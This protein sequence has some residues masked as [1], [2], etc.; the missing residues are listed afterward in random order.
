M[1]SRPFVQY[2]AFEKETVS[3]EFRHQNFSRIGFHLFLFTLYFSETPGE[4]F[5][6]FG[7]SPLSMTQ[8]KY[9]SVSLKSTRNASSV[10]MT[11]ESD[12]DQ[13]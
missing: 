12:A 6:T 2:Y 11:L 13:V 4:I 9:A 8:V 10:S 7:A 1:F 3:K 5:E